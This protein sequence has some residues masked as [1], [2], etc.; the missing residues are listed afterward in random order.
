MN[1]NLNQSL[2]LIKEF[3]NLQ[4]CEINAKKAYFENCDLTRLKNFEYLKIS[5]Q[6]K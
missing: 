2:K 5:C 1:W 6:E 4:K 3:E